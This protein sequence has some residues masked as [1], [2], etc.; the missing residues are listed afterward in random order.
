MTVASALASLLATAAATLAVPPVPIVRPGE[1]DIVGQVPTVAYWFMGWRTWDANTLSRTQRL[2]CWHIR[3][4]YP[5]GPRITPSTDSSVEEWLEVAT[6]AIDN[7]LWGNVGL[8]GAATGQGFELT[9]PQAGW[10]KDANEAESRVVDW[11]LA[12]MLSNVATIAV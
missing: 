2:S 6:A 3:L 7:K 11:D 8:L 10:L 9:E 1:P 12:A 4:Y 5:I